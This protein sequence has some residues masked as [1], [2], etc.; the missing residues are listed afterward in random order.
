MLMLML[1]TSLTREQDPEILKL[2]HLG[3]KEKHGLRLG[4]DD[5]HQ[6]R[7]TLSSAC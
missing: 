2:P 4:S 1:Y 6:N 7:Y 3:Q 5:S